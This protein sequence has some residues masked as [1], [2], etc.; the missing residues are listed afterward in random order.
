[1]VAVTG[2]PAFAQPI[3]IATLVGVGGYEQ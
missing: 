3:E 1:M 2:A